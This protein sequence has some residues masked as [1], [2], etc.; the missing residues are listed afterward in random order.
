MWTNITGEP[1]W[2]VERSIGSLFGMPVE[3]VC[4]G[5]V[6]TREEALER[7]KKSE[8]DLYESLWV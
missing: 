4:E 5:V 1:Y 2:R 8:H 7:L 3:G 6:R